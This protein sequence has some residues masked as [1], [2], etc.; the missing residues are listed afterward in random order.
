L[1]VIIGNGIEEL[2]EPTEFTRNGLVEV[3]EAV[4][5]SGVVMR[6]DEASTGAIGAAE[7]VDTTPLLAGTKKLPR[8][9]QGELGNGPFAVRPE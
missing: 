9:W 1:L 2:V 3:V 7:D 5:V 6:T 8:E 4:R